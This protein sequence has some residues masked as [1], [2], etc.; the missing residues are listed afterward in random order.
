MVIP[1]K[2]IGLRLPEQSWDGY[3]LMGCL[4]P[5]AVRSRTCHQMS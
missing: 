2:W 3:T 1:R 5:M 4:R